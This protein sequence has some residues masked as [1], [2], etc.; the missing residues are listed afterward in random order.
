M[1]SH[2]FPSSLHLMSMP[3]PLKSLTT[4]AKHLLKQWK[5][6]MTWML[7]NLA[8][9]G[10]AFLYEATSCCPPSCGLE[11]RGYVT[12]VTNLG[13]KTAISFSDHLQAHDGDMLFL[14]ITISGKSCQFKERSANNKYKDLLR[15]VVP[16]SI[17]LQRGA[18]F[19]YPHTKN[20]GIDNDNC[21]SYIAGANLSN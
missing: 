6:L 10:W 20:N 15:S 19:T 17:W 21:P 16:V 13:F 11:K 4:E 5:M 18:H 1:I 7:R 3:I 9:C 2:Y 12:Q 14:I 8:Y